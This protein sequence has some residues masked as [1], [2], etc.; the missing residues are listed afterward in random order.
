MLWRPDKHEPLTDTRWDAGRAQ[1]SIAEIVTDA[2]GAEAGGAWPGHPLDDVREDEHFW[3]RYPGGAGV[4]GAVGGRGPA[5]DCP[6]P[7]AT[8]LER[9][10]ARPD[11]ESDAHP[12][13]LLM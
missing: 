2:E 11:F 3:S 6:A 8:A 12:P 5:P 7:P 9:S 13:S 1:D 4:I 10:R